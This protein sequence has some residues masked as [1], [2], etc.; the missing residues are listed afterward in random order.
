MY[1]VYARDLPAA[2]FAASMTWRT[3]A[4]PRSQTTSITSVSS[5]CSAGGGVGVCSIRRSV[6][7]HGSSG[8]R[9]AA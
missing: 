5:S 4:S 6:V 9:A 3:E 8:K 2:G 7:D 1:V